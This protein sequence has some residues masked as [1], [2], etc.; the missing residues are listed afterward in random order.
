MS[1]ITYFEVLSNIQNKLNK[2]LDVSE[3]KLLLHNLINDESNYPYIRDQFYRSQIKKKKNKLAENEQITRR[4]MFTAN[5]ILDKWIELENKNEELIDYTW[6]KFL[7]SHSNQ[8]NKKQLTITNDEE[9]IRN[10][11]EIKLSKLEYLKEKHI[12]NLPEVRK[13]EQRKKEV[14]MD[15]SKYPILNEK[16]LV[17]KEMGIRYGFDTD[18][19]DKEAR[20]EL[21][22]YWIDNFENDLDHPETGKQRYFKLRELYN[23]IGYELSVIRN[24]LRKPIESRGQN[25][26]L[27]REFDLDVK[28]YWESMID[29]CFD[30]KNS[31]HIAS[32]LKIEKDSTF[33]Q[34]YPIF[35]ELDKK[36][37]DDMESP[38]YIMLAEFKNTLG[39]TDLTEMEKDIVSLIIGQNKELN[40]HKI[41][42][43]KNPY[44]LIADY[45]NNKY[46]KNKNKRDIVNIIN[47]KISGVLANTYIELDKG[48]DTKKCTVC[49]IDK[50]ASKSNFGEDTRK[51]DGL[52]SVC[53]KCAAEAER[54]R[55]QIS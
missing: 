36:Y 30:L 42:Y 28:S 49:R 17:Y 35:Y 2:Q 10:S 51:K 31:K 19:Y 7:D 40:I 20:K 1:T 6:K 43:N 11:H 14:M 3:R 53:K 24:Q 45:I 41:D 25:Q 55:K 48:I 32:L 23:H 5:Y 13:Q 18:I 12:Y 50:L 15:I 27:Q 33:G 34:F 46:G 38:I 29:K 47:K 21:K 44:S 8:S 4:L 54:K 37:K 16:Y 39:L 9:S 22:K 52:K 26:P